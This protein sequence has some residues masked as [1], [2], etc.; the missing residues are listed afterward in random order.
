MRAPRGALPAFIPTAIGY[1]GSDCLI[2][3]YGLTTTGYGQVRFPGIRGTAARVVCTLVHGA[4]PQDKPHVAHWCGNRACVA[5]KHLRW[6]TVR[7]NRMD[8]LRHGT[9]SRGSDRYNSRLTEADVLAI[10]QQTWRTGR[11][12]AVEFGVAETTISAIRGGRRWRYLL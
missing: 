12:F 9:E 4:P 10:R 8:K 11:S 2:W 3:P 1:A 5:P 6:A 7:E